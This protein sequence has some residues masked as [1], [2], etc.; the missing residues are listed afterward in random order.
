MSALEDDIARIARLRGR[1][2]AEA[3]ARA[4]EA[5]ERLP[6]PSRLLALIFT[7]DGDTEHDLLVFDRLPPASRQ[8]IYSAPR[9]INSRIWRDALA[10]LSQREDVLIDLVKAKLETRQ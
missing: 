7:M 4:R 2:P 9:P 1:D 3:L 8:F 10:I 6:D 5:Q